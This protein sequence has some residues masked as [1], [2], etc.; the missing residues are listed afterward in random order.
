MILIGV[1]SRVERITTTST[2]RMPTA[3][4]RLATPSTLP[5]LIHLVLQQSYEVAPIYYSHLTKKLKHKEV[6]QLEN[7]HKAKK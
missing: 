5:L 7:S 3:Y 6:K 2:S 1:G 4:H